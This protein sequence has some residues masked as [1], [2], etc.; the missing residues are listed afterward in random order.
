MQ[1][2]QIFILL[3]PIAYLIGAIPT[4]IWAG[5]L[6]YGIDVRNYG[7]GNA[8][9]TNA[10]RVLGF[11]V[12]L[13]VL[14]F[15]IFKG[16]AAVQIVC[17]FPAITCGTDLFVNLR[18]ILGICAVIGHIFPVYAGFRGGKGVAAI[19]GALLALHPLASVSAGGVF[20][21]SLLISKYVSVSSILAGLSFPVWIIFVYNSPYLYLRIFSGI[22]S[23][24]IIITHIRN[25][26]KLIKGEEKKAG[27]IFGKGKPKN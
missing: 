11:R 21:I 7:S 26:R 15:D 17:F 13:P 2:I 23:V 1:N 9:A 10:M 19:F 24:M 4:A 20:I 6:F 14:L 12:G 5:K 22:I 25:I 8:G 18:I 27:F 16:W 3:I